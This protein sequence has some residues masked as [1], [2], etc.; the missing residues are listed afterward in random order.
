MAVAEGC[1]TACVQPLAGLLDVTQRRYKHFVEDHG[2]R[3]CAD[4]DVPRTLCVRCAVQN[5]SIAKDHPVTRP[6]LCAVSRVGSQ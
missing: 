3:Q 2:L 4:A 1:R 5:Q 6:H